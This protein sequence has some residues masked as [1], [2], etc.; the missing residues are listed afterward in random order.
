MS[1]MCNKSAASALT[2]G[3]SVVDI[4]QEDDVSLR[5]G[6]KL[7]EGRGALPQ[8]HRPPLKD[9]HQGQPLGRAEAGAAVVHDAVGADVLGGDLIH[10]A[11]VQKI[12][13]NLTK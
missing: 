11:T 4:V 12:S 13:E 6:V 7:L 1:W 2:N 3:V 9:V 8:V 10:T 5:V